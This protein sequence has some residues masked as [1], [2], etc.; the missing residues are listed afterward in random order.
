M[1]STASHNEMPSE[2]DN[3]EGDASKDDSKI[4]SESAESSRESSDD[5]LL[6]YSESSILSSGKEF[7]PETTRPN[8]V[9]N[10]VERPV[11]WVP[12]FKERVGTAICRLLNDSQKFC[13]N[14]K[15][16]APPI[17]SISMSKV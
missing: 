10:L 2:N 3:S 8:E 11:T 14:G 17:I 13:I 16:A 4:N 1:A 12:T 5:S 6:E 15:M 7:G 9:D